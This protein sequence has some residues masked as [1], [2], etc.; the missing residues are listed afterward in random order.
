MIITI[1]WLVPTVMNS[2]LSGIVPYTFFFIYHP[3][4]VFAFYFTL[5]FVVVVCYTSICLKVRCNR[6]PRHHGAAGVKER[7]LTG[8]LLL[9]TFGSLIT[10]LPKIFFWGFWLPS[11]EPVFNFLHLVTIWLF[12]DN[13]NICSGQLVDKSYNLCYTNAWGKNKHIIN[14]FP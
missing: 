2:I 5:L 14:N 10:F 1:I 7:K 6:L 8:T 9:V 12:D 13:N 3:I 11:P 4:I